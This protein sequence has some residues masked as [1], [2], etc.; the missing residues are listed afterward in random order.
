[1]MAVDCLTLS[2]LSLRKSA[3]RRPLTDS[4][5]INPASAAIAYLHLFCE[6]DIADWPTLK[7]ILRRRLPTV[8]RTATAGSLTPFQSS[9][10]EALDTFETLRALEGDFIRSGGDWFVT[11]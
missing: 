1:M 4:S 10:N 3:C 7:E 6:M 5:K 9:L 8:P 2:L 11:A